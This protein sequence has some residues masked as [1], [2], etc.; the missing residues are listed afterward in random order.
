MLEGD[1]TAMQ[2][3]KVKSM[4]LEGSRKTANTKLY[5]FFTG[6]GNNNTIKRPSPHTRY[7]ARLQG[8]A[9]G[10]CCCYLQQ[11]EATVPWSM[12]RIQNPTELLRP[13]TI[14]LTN[15]KLTQTKPK[16]AV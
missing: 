14:I 10:A 16:L 8:K 12:N 11:D 9:L 1:I 6:C 13:Q 15:T 2:K 4:F 3:P 7:T 5:A